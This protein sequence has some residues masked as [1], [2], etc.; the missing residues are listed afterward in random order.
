MRGAEVAVLIEDQGR[1]FA[2]RQAS[3]NGST[4]GLG[5]TAMQERTHLVGGRFE[6]A[7]QPGKG[8]RLSAIVPLGNNEVPA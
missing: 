2:A 3:R 7:S 1:G 5:L 6:C 8:T 4:E